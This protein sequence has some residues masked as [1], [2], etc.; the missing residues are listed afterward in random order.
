MNKFSTNTDK[1][2]S[3]IDLDSYSYCRYISALQ[4]ESGKSEKSHLSSFNIDKMELRNQICKIP[5]NHFV[6]LKFLTYL[7]IFQATDALM[8][9][10][11]PNLQTLK[12][13]DCVDFDYI[14][15]FLMKCEK[16]K[17]LSF[18]NL[19]SFSVQNFDKFKFKLEN[20]RI[21]MTKSM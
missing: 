19:K 10:Q 6:H 2:E 12:I 1:N 8:W 13:H 4:R 14:S 18:T 21:V 17:Y 7:E 9:I 11:V 20:L 5:Q 16:L 15:V 3:Q